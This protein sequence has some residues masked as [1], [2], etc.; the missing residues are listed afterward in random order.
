MIKS[1]GVIKH[2]QHF[3]EDRKF[4]T[5]LPAQFILSIVITVFADAVGMAKDKTVL[6]IAHRI[7]PWPVLT[8]S[9]D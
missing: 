9:W 3:C 2:E 8:R 4:L 7:E 5:D 6:I 1:R